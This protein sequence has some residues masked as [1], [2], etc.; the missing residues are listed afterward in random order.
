MN[1]INPYTVFAA[2]ALFLIIFAIWKP[3]VSRIVLGIFLL[4]MA[5]GVNLPFILTDPTHI[6]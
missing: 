6:C 2:F 3:G 1:I 5:L 4:I